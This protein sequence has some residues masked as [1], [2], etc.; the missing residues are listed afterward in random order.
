M[1]SLLQEIELIRDFADEEKRAAARAI[2]SALEAATPRASGEGARSWEAS[3]GSPDLAEGE[4]GAGLSGSINGQPLFVAPG[5]DHV[6][7]LAGGRYY[8]PVEKR[9]Q[10]SEQQPL[11]G[12]IERTADRAVGA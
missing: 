12:W 2:E 9:W 8:N 1:S 11:G 7:V 10:G 6:A 4:S 5:A 3:I